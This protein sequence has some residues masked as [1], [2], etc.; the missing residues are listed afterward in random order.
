VYIVLWGVLC[1]KYGW[2]SLELILFGVPTHILQFHHIFQPL[3]TS[4]TQHTDVKFSDF[5]RV[6]K[7][8]GLLH[9]TS[10]NFS[11]QHLT[12]VGPFSTCV[13]SEPVSYLPH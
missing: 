5:K 4:K 11:L 7:I 3:L 2:K 9:Q 6:S 1:S 12:P 8:R 10:I 13:P